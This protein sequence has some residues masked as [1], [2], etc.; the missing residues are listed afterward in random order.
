MYISGEPSLITL[1]PPSLDFT[2]TI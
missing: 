2:V 1:S